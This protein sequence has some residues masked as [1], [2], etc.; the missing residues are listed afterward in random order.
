MKMDFNDNKP[1]YLQIVDFYISEIV[2][3]SLLPNDKL[4]SVREVSEAFKVN[5]NTVQRAFA[6]MERQGLTYTKRGIGSFIVDDKTKLLDLKVDTVYLMID[7]FIDDMED[8]GYGQEEIISLIKKR[9]E[10]VSRNE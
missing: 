6:E 5:P 3:G 2:E 7:R 8:L 4:P 9:Y 1:I 10:D